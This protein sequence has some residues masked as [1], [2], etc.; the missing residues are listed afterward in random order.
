MARNRVIYQSEALF[1]SPNATGAHFTV[2]AVLTGGGMT[3]S[4]SPGLSIEPQLHSILP[5]G[6]RVDPLLAQR[7][8]TAATA[9]ADKV[10]NKSNLIN[11]DLF[12]ISGK[13]AAT[14]PF[15]G[16]SVASHGNNTSAIIGSRFSCG[17]PTSITKK[18]EETPT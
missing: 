14:S 16:A 4:A 6:L 13:V 10:A 17:I 3:G 1:T 18:L 15:S 7:D 11:E 8:A 12:N 9:A 5:V 2:S